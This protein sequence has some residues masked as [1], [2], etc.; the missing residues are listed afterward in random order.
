V[1]NNVQDAVT[2]NIDDFLEWYKCFFNSVEQTMWNKISLSPPLKLWFPGS[3]PIKNKLNYHLERR[4]YMPVLL[5]QLIVLGQ[6]HV[7]LQLSWIALLGKTWALRTMKTV[8]FRKYSFEKRTQFSLGHKIL[9]L[10]LLTNMIFYL[11][12]HVF[13]Q[14]SW[15]GLSGWHRAFLPV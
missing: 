1:G 11:G 14:I 10:V 4:F 9:I 15:K 13:F 12:I 5:T 3:F 8:I 2:S 6:I 7:F